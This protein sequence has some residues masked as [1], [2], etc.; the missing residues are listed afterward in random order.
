ML[1]KK[2]QLQ[3]KGGE[4]V[5]LLIYAVQVSSNYIV[6]LCMCDR[7][8]LFGKHF[9]TNVSKEMGILLSLTKRGSAEN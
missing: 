3:R 7:S 2:L 8:D 1:K 6:E 4:Q 5:E 9:G